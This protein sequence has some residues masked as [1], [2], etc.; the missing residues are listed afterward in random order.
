MFTYI[1]VAIGAVV[2]LA[3][4]IVVLTL[5]LLR[6]AAP[7][8]F[9]ARPAA[10]GL[11][12]EQLAPRKVGFFARGDVEPGEQDQTW[13]AVYQGARGEIHLKLVQTGSVREAARALARLRRQGA[14][15]VVIAAKIVGDRS[16]LV[17]KQGKGRLIGW[18]NGEWA[19]VAASLDAMLL[20]E[21]VREYPY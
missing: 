20:G 8:D 21:F 5:V 17:K 15:R 1:V 14:V 10:S 19:F 2:L 13:Q 18:T 7:A 16:F 4:G 9:G 6:A 12:A 3:A 11:V